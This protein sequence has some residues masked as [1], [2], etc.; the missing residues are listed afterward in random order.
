MSLFEILWKGLLRKKS[1]AFWKIGAYF[2]LFV[3][4]VLA[5]NW[6]T[7]SRSGVESSL[8]KT[9]AQFGGF[10]LA[11][12]E[13]KYS[14][15][16]RNPVDEGFVVHLNPSELFSMEL[17]E[18]IR[19]SPHV[20]SASP[21]LSFRYVWNKNKPRILQIGGF[22]P[23]SA[24]EIQSAA[25]SATDLLAGRLLK[26]ED[27]F[28][29]LLEETFATT[30]NLYPG[31]TLILNHQSFEVIGILSPG[32]RPAKADIYMSLNEAKVLINTRLKKNIGEEANMVLVDGLNSSVHQLAIEDAKKIL[33]PQSSV[34]G[35]GCYKPASMAVQ[36]TQSITQLIWIMVLISLLLL[37]FL[38][39]YSSIIER[40]R[41]IGIL[42]AIAWSDRFI[43]KQILGEVS[44]EALLGST[45][46]AFFAFLLLQL[47]PTTLSSIIGNKATELVSPF[48]FLQGILLTLISAWL[49]AW[50]CVWV[51]LRINA[52][53]ILRK[54]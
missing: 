18:H 21:F 30:E 11:I 12:D 52:A 51:I 37:V 48:I 17:I 44:L 41:E 40:K 28:K 6:S 43:V 8:Q 9:G 50:V 7:T 32:T 46:G 24:K 23:Q 2:L 5:I 38:M 53:D 4:F 29:V 3:F 25:C 1:I 36:K 16:L 42:K 14:E 13:E 27:T 19:Q 15:N 31:N 49:T 20:R 54:I 22:E 39:Q 45:L 33:G 34:I 26:P 35:F 10:I 47:F